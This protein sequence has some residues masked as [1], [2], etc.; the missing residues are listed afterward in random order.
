MVTVF[1]HKDTCLQHPEIKWY[2]FS[3]K[4]RYIRQNYI[5]N[6]RPNR[7]KYKCSVI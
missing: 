1:G 3:Y 2:T 7:W 6:S 4:V 5:N